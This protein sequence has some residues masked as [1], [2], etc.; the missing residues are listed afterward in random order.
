MSAGTVS[1]R[2]ALA[3]WADV[4]SPMRKAAFQKFA[5]CGKEV[6]GAEGERLRRLAG[7]E[8]KEEFAAF[9]QQ[10][11]RCLLEVM[12][13]FPSVHPPLGVSHLLLSLMSASPFL[14]VSNSS[15][16]LLGRFL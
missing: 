7:P 11:Q 10:P 14:D 8:G 12:Q 3:Q 15:K 5:E 6:G 4:L 2:T 13:A 16:S 1:L 9:V